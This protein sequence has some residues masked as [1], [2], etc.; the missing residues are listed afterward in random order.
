MAR[1]YVR[2]NYLE[3]Q[4]VP[5]EIAAQTNYEDPEE[6]V[7]KGYKA[8]A[9]DMTD[10]LDYVQRG[11]ME[12]TT[13]D[14]AG[15]PVEIEPDSILEPSD[16]IR[17]FQL[18]KMRETNVP[19]KKRIGEV[20]EEIKLK[21]DEYIGEFV[22][23]LYDNRNCVMMVQSNKF[24]LTIK[25]IE[26][27]LTEL[28]RRYITL[29]G[30]LPDPIQWVVKLV[31]IVDMK[32]VENVLKAHNYRKMTIRGSDVMLDASLKENGLMSHAT[33]LLMKSSGV[34]FN[35]SV[36][37]SKAPKTETLDH[38][39]IRELIEEYK[40]LPDDQKPIVE[41]SQRKDDT[42]DIEIINLLE[43]RIYDFISVVMEPR[44][45]I[46]FMFLYNLMK[47]K[48]VERRAYIA[49]VLLRIE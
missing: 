40:D 5:A 21:D 41:I 33:R 4:L 45:P 18:T 31:P 9:W 44:A 36:S 46:G 42:D 32:R 6:I 48:Y 16:S 26:L 25:Q 17:G 29:A 35:I 30:L 3:A 47:E 8:S 38:A 15:E 11:D 34:T 39:A 37:M 22:S 12:N 49:K 19:S 1:K 10:L 13:I 24:S 20:S 14:V 28:R 2:F 27:Y 23:I 43:P 7:K